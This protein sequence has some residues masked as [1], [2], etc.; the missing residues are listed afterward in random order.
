MELDEDLDNTA[1]VCSRKIARVERSNPQN[2]SYHVVLLVIRGRLD[3]ALQ[4]ALDE[5]LLAQ[6]RPRRYERL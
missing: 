1:T 4:K 2:Q 3:V 6:A 5:R